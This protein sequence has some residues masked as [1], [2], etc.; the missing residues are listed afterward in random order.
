[1]PQ[2]QLYA[3]VA[4]SSYIIFRRALGL[5]YSLNKLLKNPK[6]NRTSTNS[7]P[8]IAPGSSLIPKGPREEGFQSLKRHL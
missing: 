1:M 6:T 8:Q 3:V 2:W 4:Q 5:S 7:N